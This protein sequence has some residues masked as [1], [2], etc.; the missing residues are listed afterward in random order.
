MM[1]LSIRPKV[2][3]LPSYSLTGDLIGFLRCGLQYRYS[4]IGR[5]PPSRPVQLWFGEFIHGV[6]EEAYRRYRDSVAKGKPALPP[7]PST[8][9]DDV[10][11]LIE[12]RLAAQGLIAWDPDLKELGHKRAEVAIQ[13]LGPHLFPIIA[14][15]EVRLSGARKLPMVPTH[16]QFRT[17]DRYEMVGVV[18]VLTQMQFND[19]SLSGN[20]LIQMILPQ[21]PGNPPPKFEVIVDYKGMRRPPCK[22]GVGTTL[23]TQ[24]AW[25]VLTYAELRRHLA[26]AKPV[27]A[28]VLVY[29]NELL[30]TRSDLQHLKKEIVAGTT[31]A[32]P[33]SGSSD[34]R[35]IRAWNTKGPLV[36]LSW[37]YRLSRAIRVVPVNDVA[38]QAAVQGFDVV[39][40]EIETCLGAEAHGGTVLKSW[41]RNPADES[42]C[43]VC[44]S[45][46]YCPDYQKLHA[47]AHG[48]KLPKL[49]GQRI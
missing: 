35:A 5:L 3:R 25:Q 19:P 2:Y 24:Y 45:R 37:G 14:E 17:A 16:L 1:A 9:L 28:G 11:N 41:K 7:W 43:V 8:L 31:D 44:D 32:P 20:P 13:E 10:R 29:I 18:D 47:A 36:S 34:D 39:V 27:V 30:P 12:Q 26:G 40:R 15:A 33:P 23:W 4:R 49:P 21:L 22:G 42:T 38:I 46:T 6:M 48:E